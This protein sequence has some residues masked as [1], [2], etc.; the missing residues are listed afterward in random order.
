MLSCKQSQCICNMKSMWTSFD[1]LT[2]STTVLNGWFYGNLTLFCSET[3]TNSYG[4]TNPIF[5]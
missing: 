4:T 5:G 1:V 3:K 2:A